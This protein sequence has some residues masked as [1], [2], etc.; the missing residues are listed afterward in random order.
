VRA[1]QFNRGVS[2]AKLQRGHSLGSLFFVVCPD[3]PLPNHT[4]HD[5][6]VPGQIKPSPV[7]YVS[8]KT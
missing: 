3:L 8:L 6:T 5:K 4:G 7:S 2:F 1:E